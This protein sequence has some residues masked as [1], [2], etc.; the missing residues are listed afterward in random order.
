[1]VQAMKEIEPTVG[2]TTT[3]GALP[4]TISALERLSWNYWW[5]WATGGNSVFRDLDP[6]VWN[7]CEHNPRRLLQDVSEYTL[8]RM[9]TDPHYIERVRRLEENF[10]AYMNPGVRTWA[11]QHA[12]EIRH[13]RPVAYFCAEFGVHHSLPLYSGGLGI[14]AGDHLKSASDL[15]L[16]LVAVGLLYH[17]GYF[18]Q[19]LRRDGWQ[20]E[21]YHQIDVDDLP[22][23]LVRDAQGEPVNVT[24]SMRGREVRVQAWRVDVGRIPLY[25]LDTNVEGN[26]EIDRMITGHLYGGDRETRCVQEMVLGI[27]GVRLLRQLNIEPHVFHLNE[28]HS[29][30]LTLELA[31]ELTAEGKQFEEAAAEVRRRC[32]FTTHTPVAAGHD[33]FVPPLV[34]AC[35]GEDYWQAL[36][37]TLEEFLNLGRVKADNDEELFGLTPLALRM[38]RS[39]NGVSRKHGEVS[40]E[41]WREMWPGRTVEEVPITSVT[42]GVHAPTWVAP[43]IRSIYE[44]HVGP[45]WDEALY[46]AESWAVKVDAIPDEELWKAKRLLKHRLFAFVRQR[47]YFARTQQGESR[48]YAEAAHQLFDS[49]ALTIGFARRV[50]AYK[51]WDLMLEDP[52]RL[53]RLMQ[54]A[55]RPVQFVFAGKAHPQDQGAKLILQQLALWKL[56]PQ[57]MQRAVFLQDYDQEIAR[58]LVQSVDVWLNVP[59]RPLEASGTS[60]EKVAL[61]GGLN[62]SVLDG[63]WPEGCDGE[64]GW[65]VNG[66]EVLESAEEMDRTDAESLYRTLEEEV[67][68]AFYER[69]AD[70][71]P[72]RWI[73]KMR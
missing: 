59:R 46:D 24:L 47:L 50:A 37:L 35:F 62:L 51:R 48:E 15:G 42:N 70:G 68:P 23:Q 34:E 57:V 21:T 60:G 20:E 32:A 49:D 7:E 29:A 12:P 67:V 10:D 71:L 72:R 27:G 28:G 11:A 2:R 36:G 39:T 41:L 9:A 18:R 54:D 43:L 63:W 14:L 26:H 6:D 58:N 52:E 33:E 22:L 53:R 17:H 66:T 8:A 3:K 65:A 45:D 55:E 31:R 73:A 69:G 25:L 16:P 61:N 1:M 38:T 5:S 13:E 64:N 30:F 56:D 4:E 19:R 40:R 44:R